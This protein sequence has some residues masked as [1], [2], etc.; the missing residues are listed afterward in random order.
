LNQYDV[1]LL[2]DP[3]MRQL[4]PTWPEMMTRFVGDAGGWCLSASCTHALFHPGLASDAGGI[5][6]DSAW[7]NSAHRATRACISR[8]PTCGS[9]NTYA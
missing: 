8:G 2:V 5:V 4:G 3:D 7:L 9:L 1:L 6:V